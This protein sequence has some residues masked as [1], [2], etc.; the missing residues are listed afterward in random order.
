M[1]KSFEANCW[2]DEEK[3]DKKT[4]IDLVPSNSSTSKPTEDSNPFNLNKMAN[5]AIN[6]V[7]STVAS[8]VV[9]KFDPQTLDSNSNL[10]ILISKTNFV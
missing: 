9:S 10:L 2:L 7:N 3:G 8:S 4:K 5:N 1:I 6:N